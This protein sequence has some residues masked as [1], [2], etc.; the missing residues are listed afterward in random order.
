MH[1][2]D[3]YRHLLGLQSPWSV[4]RVELSVKDQRVDVWAEHEATRW[5]CPECGAALPLY[6]HAEERSW[7]HLDSC[8][9][10]TYLR[11]RIPRIDCPAHGVKQV[12]V[13]WAEPKSRFTALFERFAIDVLRETDVLG[14]TRILRLSWDEAWHVMEK[15]VERGL[16]RKKKR[17]VARL[18][19]DE[20]SVAKG[21]SYITLV[22]DVDEGTV[23]HIADDRKQESLDGYFKQLTTRQLNTIQA[24]AMDMWEP[25]YRSALAH[26]PDAVTKIVFDKFHIMGHMGAAVDLV[27]R[28][29]HRAK[30]AEGD[31]IL[32]GS[33]YLWLYGEENVPEE[34]RQRFDA[35][36]DADLKTGRAWAIKEV[37][38]GLWGYRRLGWARHHFRRW[39]HWAT[40]SRLQ[41]V[42]KAAKMVKRHLANV[43]TYFE[44]RLTNA[45]AE[46]LNSKIQTIKKRAYGFRNRENF[47]TA[48][49][50]N[51][52]GLDLY[53]ATHGKA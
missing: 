39:Y 41:P 17:T 6:D 36:K 51:C 5:P 26:V 47:K 27:R 23:E 30:K 8:Q 22:C 48:I 33:K 45:V 24:I 37:L 43:L 10:K 25:Y 50:F 44:H 28:R 29:E 21:Q 18:G 7:R 53:P 52:G 15:A 3:L 31:S 9:F 13:P 1:D 38:R 42:I 14:A 49:Y 40:H 46:G 2:V 11:A 16:A 34:H 4:A 35:L 19:I 20:K 32:T 12:R